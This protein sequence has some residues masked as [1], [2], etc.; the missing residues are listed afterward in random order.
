MGE[1]CCGSG[2]MSCGE[3]WVAAPGSHWWGPLAGEMTWCHTGSSP[4]QLISPPTGAREAPSMESLQK[5]LRHPTDSISRKASQKRRRTRK[6]PVS[7]VGVKGWAVLFS[8][9][10]GVSFWDPQYHY[11][12]RFSKVTWSKLI[13]ALLGALNL[14]KK[15]SSSCLSTA[16]ALLRSAIP[17]FY[18]VFAWLSFWLIGVETGLTS[19]HLRLISS[20]IFPFPRKMHLGNF[21]AVGC[22]AASKKPASCF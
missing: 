16:L 14:K 9:K 13:C 7:A 8:R 11:Y 5:L 20:T 21:S 6:N 19:F 10:Q 15:K 1:L 3:E 4:N 17:I 2:L 22:W 18:T 12:V